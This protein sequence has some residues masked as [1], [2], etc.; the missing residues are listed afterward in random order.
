MTLDLGPSTDPDVMLQLF[1][2]IPEAWVGAVGESRLAVATRIA[3]AIV[4]AVDNAPD[5]EKWEPTMELRV[6]E[7]FKYTSVNTHIIEQKYIHVSGGSTYGGRH[8]T[9]WRPLPMVGVN[10]EPL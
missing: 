9:E 6:R 7:E 8:S 4:D 1:D 10:G 3:D 5:I 2:L